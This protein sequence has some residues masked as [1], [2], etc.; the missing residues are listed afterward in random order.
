[1]YSLLD[2]VKDCMKSVN[3]M[4]L[5]SGVL[6]ATFAL[7]ALGAPV[8]RD[9]N[10]TNQTA[11]EAALGIS[12]ESFD[13]VSKICNFYAFTDTMTKVL[14]DNSPKHLPLRG[15]VFDLSMLREYFS[16]S[17]PESIHVMAHRIAQSEDLDLSNISVTVNADIVDFSRN[18]KLTLK[19]GNLSISALSAIGKITVDT[20][21]TYSDD[22]ALFERDIPFFT[23]YGSSKTF[24]GTQFTC[25][26][27][28]MVSS[29]LEFI[30]KATVQEF[31]YPV[32]TNITSWPSY[33]S[34]STSQTTPKC[35]LFAAS[36]DAP[37]ILQMTRLRF[38]PL[39]PEKIQEKV[40][41][42][43]VELRSGAKDVKVE[44][45]STPGKAHG[46]IKRGES[47]DSLAYLL[48]ASQLSDIM[49]CIE[50]DAH[51]M[52]TLNSAFT[53]DCAFACL[54]TFCTPFCYVGKCCQCVKTGTKGPDC[55][56]GSMYSRISASISLDAQKRKEKVIFDQL[57]L[58][59]TVCKERADNAEK[60]PTN[61]LA[62]KDYGLY[63]SILNKADQLLTSSKA[64]PIMEKAMRSIP[65]WQLILDS[66]EFGI[67]EPKSFIQA[68]GGNYQA[69]LLGAAFSDENN[70][71]I[72]TVTGNEGKTIV[73]EDLLPPDYSTAVALYSC[74]SALY[75]NKVDKQI[76]LSVLQPIINRA[77]SAPQWSKVEFEALATE[78]CALMNTVLQ[79]KSGLANVP[80]LD[81]GS[82][83]K[84]TGIMKQS[85][86][87]YDQQASTFFAAESITDENVK[88]AKAAL[89]NYQALANAAKQGMDI[90]H[91][92]ISSDIEVHYALK[93]Q[94]DQQ[95]KQL[96]AARSKFESGLKA[97]EDRL[98]GEMELKIALGIAG[99]IAGMAFGAIESIATFARIVEAFEDTAKLLFKIKKLAQVFYELQYVLEGIETILDSGS[100]KHMN[101]PSKAWSPAMSSKA[102]NKTTQIDITNNELSSR[103]TREEF[104]IYIKKFV[105]LGVDGAGDYLISALHLCDLMDAVNSGML[106]AITDGNAFIA[107]SARYQSAQ[108][109]VASSQKLLDNLKISNQEIAQ[110]YT[111]MLQH[112]FDA[113]QYFISNTVD[114]C[115]ALH[116]S[117]LDKC[118]FGIESL[119]SMD[120]EE[121]AE[122]SA[123]VETQLVSAGDTTGDFFQINEEL[124]V[125]EKSSIDFLKEKRMISITIPIDSI[126]FYRYD[127]IRVMNVDVILNGVKCGGS[128][129]KYCEETG[130]EVEIEH[131]S[132]MENRLAGQEYSFLTPTTQRYFYERKLSGTQPPNGHI[133]EPSRKYY[134][135]AP[136]TQWR[137]TVDQRYNKGVD[138]S[139]V[140]SL[141]VTFWG[142]A[143][144]SSLAYQQRIA[145]KSLKV[146]FF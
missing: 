36:I 65:K 93:I 74:G 128:D 30:R 71:E 107:A 35:T 112:K 99:A 114:L 122:L 1:M 86:L 75:H 29:D 113:K 46:V 89:S 110:V 126:L 72:Q 94:Y 95:R 56:T 81:T 144:H 82:Y 8:N 88:A 97:Y 23:K 135:P 26:V 85:L 52:S 43:N 134:I 2:M 44:L 16:D 24:F 6:L 17:K 27:P 70:V 68:W 32:N 127:N 98:K 63:S 5:T 136:F 123:S 64:S 77:P 40:N 138:L 37:L 3:E 39:L 142:V 139:E 69:L 120:V 90:K 55:G 105:D 41:G 92:R 104:T 115:N 119:F 146:D 84:I 73:H 25:P 100:V 132:K 61:I 33:F 53:F 42:G 66:N 133:Y 103:E 130:Y 111:A 4:F 124:F 38:L 21:S 76:T 87:A 125:S 62:K 102:L 34:H 19:N 58:I 118:H 18:K 121:L 15:V 83:A 131:S 141:N 67:K 20:S 101:D 9:I 79:S 129:A 48:A 28:G 96:Q 49:E 50:D 22:R 140:S 116:F 13:P 10:G 54:Q 108:A 91:S 80:L 106:A 145:S 143:K 109:Q 14:R 59:Y 117:L 57:D 45:V 12:L 11:N 51:T 31:A 78:S 137:F 47:S 60:S 7:I